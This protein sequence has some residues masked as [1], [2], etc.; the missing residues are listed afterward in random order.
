MAR[1][2]AIFQELRSS[3]QAKALRHVFFAE[4]AVSKVPGLE[5]A[6]GRKI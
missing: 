5:N 1:E 2:R 3:D 6:V 4:R